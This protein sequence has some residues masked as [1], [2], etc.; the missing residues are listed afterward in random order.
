MEN[1][2]IKLEALKIINHPDYQSSGIH[3][4]DVALIRIKKI[5]GWPRFF[6]IIEFRYLHPQD[7][8]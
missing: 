5:T 7:I 1:T 3:A 4:N 2:A 6:G 8:V